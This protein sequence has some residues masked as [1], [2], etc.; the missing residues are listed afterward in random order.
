M[1]V[2]TT[3]PS[4]SRPISPVKST[5]T[6]HRDTRHRTPPRSLRTTASTPAATIDTRSHISNLE[7]VLLRS[8]P[9]PPSL[10]PVLHNDDQHRHNPKPSAA[11]DG[12]LLN[13]LNLSS[14][15]SSVRSSV[16]A[17][18]EVSPRSLAQLQ[19]LLSDSSRPSPK[20]SIASRWRLL[21][22]SRNWS[23][24]LD[25]LDENLRRELVRYGDLVQAA[26]RIFHSNPSASP[27]RPRHMV[28]P[29]RNYRATRSL[30]ATSSV[31]I[32][33]WLNHAASSAPPWMTQSSSWIGFVAVC[34]NEREIAR[35]GRRDIVVA[36]RGTATALEWA[37]N[38]RTTLH[39]M[40]DSP[41][42]KISSGFMNLYK[43]SPGSTTPSLSTAIVNE[44]RR[45]VAQYAGEELSITI[46]GHSLGAALAILIADEL[47][48]EIENAPPIAVVSFG[49]PRV[50]NREFAD[51]V[52]KKGVKVLRVVNTNDL[53]TRVPA[54]DHRGEKEKGNW[55]RSHL[56]DGLEGYAHVGT[57]LRVDNRDS[58]YLKPNADPACCHDLEAYL[59]LVDGFMGTGCPFRS[60]AK[61]SLA[62]LL[63]QQRPNV[64]KIYVNRVWSLGAVESGRG[65]VEVHHGC[66][67]SPSG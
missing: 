38:L 2:G 6:S 48:D 12:G 20:T 50:G 56:L 22:G 67:V 34:D 26:Y 53:V 1:T 63:S 45:L 52:E 64:K 61:R 36:L 57:E 58:P 44:I 27:S 29:D 42:A 40:P 23:G 8:T 59:H 13:A 7:R 39:P 9:H 16:T 25:P 46:T 65:A 32:P 4:P 17:A 15:F 19:R 62:R 21:H 3:I 51:R 54:G 55:L 24:L 49:G 14:L 31:E 11:N 10:F 5:T 35:M 66:L 18:D 37:E 60:N 30:F 33:S 28:L 43:S 47:A 41:S